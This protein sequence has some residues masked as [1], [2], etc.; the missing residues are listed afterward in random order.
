MCRGKGAQKG[1]KG[2]WKV[3]GCGQRERL[4]AGGENET[5]QKK[6]LFFSKLFIEISIFI[7]PKFLLKVKINYLSFYQNG[8]YS[9]IDYCL[10]LWLSLHLLLRANWISKQKSLFGR[11]KKEYIFP[12]STYL[13][14]QWGALLRS[15]RNLWKPLYSSNWIWMS[16]IQ[17]KCNNS[18]L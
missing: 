17:S 18:P 8:Q 7:A 5:F 6:L 1:E 10:I 14:S 15:S 12:A 16:P 4:Q 13:N 11:V 2:C 3:L 9:M